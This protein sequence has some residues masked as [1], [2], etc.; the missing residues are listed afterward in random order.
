MKKQ[1]QSV[2]KKIGV[3]LMLI[4]ALPLIPVLLVLL[5][6]YMLIATIWFRAAIACSYFPRGVRFLVVYSDSAQW[7]NYFESEVMPALG[8]GVR[9]INLSTEGGRKGRWEL[10]WQLYRHTCGYRDRFPVVYKFT[11]LGGWKTVRF[12]DAFMQAKRGETAALEQSKALIYEW[13]P[14]GA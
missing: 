14:K 13:S 9:S 11:R 4:G 12:Y 2:W 6:I 10:D 1:Q 3:A 8:S 5:A 7:K